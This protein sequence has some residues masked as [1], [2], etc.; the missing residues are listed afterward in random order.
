MINNN[1]YLTNKSAIQIQM[2]NDVNIKY[3]CK[4]AG[5]GD[6]YYI[7]DDNIFI[8]NEYFSLSS[9]FGVQAIV[10]IEQVNKLLRSPHQLYILDSTGT[11]FVSIMSKSY[12]NGSDGG[13]ADHCQVGKKTYIY[14]ICYANGISIPI[15]K[16]K[17]P[18]SKDC[19]DFVSINYNGRI[20]KINV[21]GDSTIGYLKRELL[22]QLD[23]ELILTKDIKFLY[24]GKIYKDDNILLD[25]LTRDRPFGLIANI[26]RMDSKIGGNNKT[27]K[28]KNKVYCLKRTKRRNML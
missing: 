6:N 9:L 1:H 20:Y 25:E 10:P 23:D 8:D 24:G 14:E 13:S 19:L 26:I 12:Y 7:Q 5:D 11:Y 3:G 28:K 27:N 17:S 21:C 2:N 15:E 18:K 4:E 22:N 16:M